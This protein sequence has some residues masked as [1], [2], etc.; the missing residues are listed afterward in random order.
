MRTWACREIVRICAL[1]TASTFINDE[2]KKGGGAAAGDPRKVCFIQCRNRKYYS[3]SQS[4]VY[5]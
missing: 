5:C 3:H 1:V 2:K 4:N